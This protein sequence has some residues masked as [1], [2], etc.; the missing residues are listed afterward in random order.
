MAQHW[1]LNIQQDLG[2]GTLTVGY[3]GNH[4]THILT[5]GVVTPI[6]INRADPV[7]S[8]RPLT[9]AYG[10]IFL[11]GGYPQSIAIGAKGL[12]Y[13]IDEADAARA[14]GVAKV[15]RRLMGVVALMGN[16][17][18]EFSFQHLADFAAAQHTIAHPLPFGVQRHEFDEAQFQA[19]V[20]S[21]SCQR[22]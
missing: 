3:V 4:V 13:R 11:V 7:T 17:R 8:A 1:S 21:E 15:N 22:H 14:V 18:T 6:N 9:E 19:M 2:V 5:D 20:A 12:G 16:E 10:D